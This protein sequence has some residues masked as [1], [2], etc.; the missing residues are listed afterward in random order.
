MMTFDLIQ[1]DPI[2]SDLPSDY[3]GIPSTDEPPSQD[4]HGYK[5]AWPTLD[6]FVNLLKEAE[7]N[8]NEGYNPKTKKW[9]PV[10]SPEGGAQTVG[11][12]FKLQDKPEYG[13]ISYQEAKNGISDVF[14]RKKLQEAYNLAK[15]KVQKYLGNRQL[16]NTLSPMRLAL[17]DLS[18]QANLSSFPK[19]RQAIQDGDMNG[20]NRE[21]MTYITKKDAA[22]KVISKIPLTR[23]FN[24]RSKYFII[25][26]R[27]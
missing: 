5:Y 14:L 2:Y 25:P 18:H 15:I 9:M 26:G 13:K 19:L 4:T 17:M 12:G 20:I 11:Y 7:S 24:L 6:E 1:E 22:G 21:F 27:N 10:G 8:M 3:E 16:N 23:R